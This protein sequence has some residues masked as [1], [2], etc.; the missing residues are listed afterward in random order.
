MGARA[1]YCPFN[2]ERAGGGGSLGA[3]EAGLHDDRPSLPC[4]I[5]APILRDSKV[6]RVETFTMRPVIGPLP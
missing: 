6:R 5:E 1:V 4:P 3:G 2:S